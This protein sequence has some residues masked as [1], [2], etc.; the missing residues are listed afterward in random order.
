VAHDFEQLLAGVDRALDAPECC[1]TASAAFNQRHVAG[2]DG[3]TCERIARELR[4][5]MAA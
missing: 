4:E 3:R 5:W 1:A 2:A